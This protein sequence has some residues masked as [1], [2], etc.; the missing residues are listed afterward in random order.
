MCKL[1]IGIKNNKNNEQF[2]QL[3]KMQ[4][5]EIVREPDGISGLVITNDGE[6]KIFRSFINYHQILNDVYSNLDNAKVVALHTRTGTSGS[7]DITNVHFFEH[8]NWIFAHNG[9]VGKYSTYENR[10]DWHGEKKM[11]IP[12]TSMT[13]EVINAQETFNNCHNCGYF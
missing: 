4:Q 1:I 7:K 5:E 3:L 6:V 10:W 12:K 13:D 8:E 11:F 9:F 2:E